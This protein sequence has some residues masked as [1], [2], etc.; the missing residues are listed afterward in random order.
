VYPVFSTVAIRS[1]GVTAGSSTV[2]V[3][4]SVAKLT[5]ALTPS[6][7]LSFFSIRVAQV[8]QV[9]PPISSWIIMMCSL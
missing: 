4:R 5:V 7:R 2:T 6:I 1:A 3:A 8:A 9:I